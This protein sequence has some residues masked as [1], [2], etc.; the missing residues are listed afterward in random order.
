MP[1]GQ[2]NILNIFGLE[3]FS[4]I[5]ASLWTIQLLSR[6]KTK[7]LRQCRYL[8]NKSLGNL[9]KLVKSKLL[10]LSNGFGI[11]RASFTSQNSYFVELDEYRHRKRKQFED[12]LRLNRL[13]I[14]VWI[15]YA[16]FEEGLEEFERARSVF[17][18]ALQQ[19]HKNQGIWM[20]Y[21]EMEMRHKFINH[22]RN[23][24]DRAVTILPRVEQFWYKYI[25]MEE[26][27]ENF[28][29]A[30]QIFERWLQWEPSEDAYLLYIKFEKR[31]QEKDRVRDVFRRFISVHPEPKNW[32]KW[33]KFEEEN[34]EFENARAVYQGAIDALG[35]EHSDEHLFISFAR[36][37]TRMKEYERARVIYQFGIESL[38]K[39]N[40][41]VLRDQFSK[42]EK[43]FGD[44]NEIELAILEKRRAH[45]EKELER[46][47]SSYDLWFEFLKLEESFIENRSVCSENDI[48]R[49]RDVY[50]KAIS[51]IPPIAEKKYWRRYIY[52]WINYALFEELT[53]GDPGKTRKV[54]RTCISIIPHKS[55]TFAK[56]WIMFAKFEIR[57]LELKNARKLLGRAIGMCP[58]PKLYK[59]YIEMELQLREI[60]RCRI[61]YEQF[62]KYSPSY[63]YAWVKFAE[64]ETL[65]EELER[66]RAIYELAVDQPLLDMPEMLWKAY[67][68]FEIELQEHD[69]ARNLYRRLLE[70]TDHP[71]VWVSFAEL[72]LS[73]REDTADSQCDAFR[74]ARSVFEEG[75]KQLKDK[76]EK[77]HVSF[78]MVVL[79]LLA[80]NF[81]VVLD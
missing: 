73:I 29:G 33:A 69:N 67:I 79:I 15:K 10:S 36:F 21:V 74:R 47:P 40:S 18:R 75:Y 25:Y 30:R 8:L 14:G 81:I 3:K 51:H 64:L 6:L 38:A 39:E 41:E 11:K 72:E 80:S 16:Q 5:L 24:F 66:A 9:P 34:T 17:E 56:I 7:I 1:S 27:L 78:L 22:A 42:F 37:E 52:L 68:D 55:F 65:L 53:V 13:N 70:K 26:M 43:Q 77:E 50:E 71:K 35:S 63:V 48:K 58:K 60:E 44:K 23:I 2:T 61:L 57:Q 59:G 19:D 62:L 32:I 49:V 46:S 45:Y 28:G 4:F 12:S 20:R 76:G 54:Y 31:Y